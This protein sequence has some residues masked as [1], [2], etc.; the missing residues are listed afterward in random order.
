MPRRSSPRAAWPRVHA[1]ILPAQF[2][3]NVDARLHDP[4]LASMRRVG[5]R[6]G[7]VDDRPQLAGREPRPDAV[8][9]RRENPCLLLHRPRPQRRPGHGQA[10]RHQPREVEL[11]RRTFHE[12]DDHQPALDGEAGDVAL[13]VGAADHV[14]DEIDT[15]AAGRLAQHRHEVLRAVVDGPLGAELHAGRAL[16]RRPGGGEDARPEQARELDG[17]RADAARSAVHE[18]RSRPP[19]AGRGR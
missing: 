6:V 13:Q 5:Q 1:F 15:A 14:E 17:H 3:F 12:G 2:P 4:V 19:A 16:G 8:A 10:P 9:Q 11:G 18:Q 7:G